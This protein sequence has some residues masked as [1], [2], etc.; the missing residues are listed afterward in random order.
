MVMKVNL[1]YLIISLVLIACSQP[2][3]V[4]PDPPES[5]Q[6]VLRSAGADS[7]DFE[8][9]IDAAANPGN[10]VNAIEMQWHTHLQQN[11]LES[12]KIYRSKHESGQINFNLLSVKEI[13]QQG[14]TDTLFRDTQDL[15]LNVRYFYYITAADKDNQESE[16][17]DTV[18]YSLLEK[19]SE[20]S[21]NGNPPQIDTTD[22]NFIWKSLASHLFYVRVEAFISEDFHPLVLLKEVQSAYGD[23]WQNLHL[24]GTWLKSALPNGSYRWRIDCVGDENIAE[25]A[26][27]GSE[28]DWANFI[29]N[30]SN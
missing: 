12:F 21:L 26:F 24:E 28:S 7:L 1:S 29:I 8:R 19:A 14:G 13:G 20:L 22:F 6:M 3:E 2:E 16:P 18:S 10:P 23:G 5:V 30:W 9:G 27:E 11:D 4:K 25:Q 17:S 15:E